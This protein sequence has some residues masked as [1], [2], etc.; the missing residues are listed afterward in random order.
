MANVFVDEMKCV[1]ETGT[2]IDEWTSD[3][4]YLLLFRGSIPTGVNLA[5]QTEF[6]VTGPG[7]F[8]NE[9][10]DGDRRTR[11][12]AVAAYDPKSLYVVQLIEQDN[13]RD[14][15]D[16][17]TAAY[18]SALNLAWTGALART[19]G[20]APVQRADVLAGTISDALRSLHTIYMGVPKQ[21]NDDPIG[22]PQRL[23]LPTR[24]VDRGA[25]LPRR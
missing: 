3:D 9:M 12:V 15:A 14:V 16:D 17:A 20:Q 1:D 18:R 19:V 10:D 24:Q 11:D 7:S 2:G 4:V 23:S 13:G 22:R 21:G 8:W 5:S 6:T 25:R